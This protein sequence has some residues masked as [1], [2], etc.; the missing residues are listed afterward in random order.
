MM[1]EKDPDRQVFVGSEQSIHVDDQDDSEDD[2]QDEELKDLL[3]NT[4]LDSS[5]SFN[6]GENKSRTSQNENSNGRKSHDE[7]IKLHQITHL[8]MK[9]PTFDPSGH[10][11]FQGPGAS[12]Y[13]NIIPDSSLIIGPHGGHRKSDDPNDEPTKNTFFPSWNHY[14]SSTAFTVHSNGMIAVID[15]C[16]ANNYI[17]FL[18]KPDGTLIS[19]SNTFMTDFGLTCL[20]FMYQD[21]NTHVLYA[22]SARNNRMYR[23]H[24]NLDPVC[25]AEIGHKS[26][27]LEA[28]HPYK[29]GSQTFVTRK[30][31]ACGK[32]RLAV[33]S[34][35]TVLLFD[36]EG[37]FVDRWAAC[38]LSSDIMDIAVTCRGDGNEDLFVLDMGHV[39]IFSE[40]KG[41]TGKILVN[42]G[43]Y[44]SVGFG[45]NS[46]KLLITEKE[47]IYEC[48]YNKNEEE[49]DI[50]TEEDEEG[51]VQKEKK[52]RKK[53]HLGEEEEEK[54]QE[55]DGGR[56]VKKNKMEDYL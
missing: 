23:I 29:A 26:L 46:N 35:R 13:S 10:I 56:D 12:I 22:L 21:P 34:S 49:A 18:F 55:A 19:K 40:L 48:E 53:I 41:Y 28:H 7:L 2:I 33:Q 42:N 5:E 39:H 1:E 44:I 3:E 47:R 4:T 9:R 6:L 24:I 37:N 11:L 25:I 27:K 43:V 20:T 31:V 16:Y 32:N 36:E 30:I 17:L 14:G 15:L 45:R 52:K 51:E 54:E 8:Q 38:I 50:E